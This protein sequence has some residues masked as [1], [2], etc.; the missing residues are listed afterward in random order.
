MP[1]S[2]RGALARPLST[3]MLT[4]STV[5]DVS[6]MS[7]ASTTRAGGRVATAP[8]ARSC[9]SWPR[10]PARRCT[11][12]SAPAS[13]SAVREI[14]AM[15]GRKASTSPGSSRSAADTRR[16]HGRLESLVAGAW[17]PA[18]VDRVRAA[19]ALDDRVRRRPSRRA[20]LAVSAVADMA[21]MRRSGRSVAAASSVSARPRSVVRLRSWTSS[22]TTS[23]TPGS[24]GSC[25][26]TTGE[27]ALGDHLDAGLRADA[28]FVARVW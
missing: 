7:V 17:P 1:T 18:D 25:L 14:S 12:T 19:G 11:S 22:K 23:P 2:K 5:S 6:A 28:A 16:D 27:H 24:S 9:S 15:P 20:K 13:R 4:P 10:A 3:T 21:R 8:S 26:Q